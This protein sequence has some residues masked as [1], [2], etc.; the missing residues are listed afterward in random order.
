MNPPP[1]LSEKPSGYS[2]AQNAAPQP[3]YYHYGLPYYPAPAY[4]Y[5]Q[6]PQSQPANQWGQGDVQPTPAAHDLYNHPSHSLS[7]PAGSSSS[8][9]FLGAPGLSSPDVEPDSGPKKRKRKPRPKGSS[10]K[11]KKPPAANDKENVAPQPVAA[12]VCGVGPSV[13]PPGPVAMNVDVPPK[14]S[15]V[16]TASDVWIHM[17]ALNTPVRPAIR[18]D[19][20]KEP[21]LLTNPTSAHSI[22]CKLCE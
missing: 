2:Q 8:Q 12:A 16:A 14:C 4:P 21:I 11:K 15:T 5:Q 17:R 13:E 10:S 3:I 7:A 19:P 22:G 6:A 18:P 1:P 9:T 20:S